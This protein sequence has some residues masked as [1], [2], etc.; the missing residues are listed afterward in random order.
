MKSGGSASKRFSF[1]SFGIMGARRR[2][3][4]RRGAGNPRASPGVTEPEGRTMRSVSL[5]GVLVAE[6]G[7]DPALD[8]LR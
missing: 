3:R 1:N 2:G 7:G 4:Q 6:E 8:W 5:A